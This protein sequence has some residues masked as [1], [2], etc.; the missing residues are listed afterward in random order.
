MRVRSWGLIRK[1]HDAGRQVERFAVLGACLMGG[2]FWHSSG[3]FPMA[4]FSGG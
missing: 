1:W 3:A 2:S 4:V